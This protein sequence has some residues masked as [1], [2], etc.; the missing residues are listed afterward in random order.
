[1]L[2]KAQL[3]LS[4][5]KYGVLSLE[6]TL[7]CTLGFQPPPPIDFNVAVTQISSVLT[8]KPVTKLSLKELFDTSILWAVPKKRRSLERRMNRKYGSKDQ[9]WKMLMPRTDLTVCNTC[10]YTHHS[11]TLCGN[12]YAKIKEETTRLQDK[13]VEALGLNPVDKEVVVLY[14]GEKEHASE[15]FSETHRVIEVE[16]ERPPWFSKNLLQKTTQKP[17]DS[18]DVKPT[19]LG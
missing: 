7:A 10:G 1:M 2:T 18:T 12:C 14:K 9:V 13:I 6:H 8:P 19:E 16:G 5:L 3:V 17:S 11:K 4:K 15:E